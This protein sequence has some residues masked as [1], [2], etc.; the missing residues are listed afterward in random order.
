[1]KA[2]GTA[3]W[4]LRMCLIMYEGLLRLLKVQPGTGQN[5]SF[6]GICEEWAGKEGGW[7]AADGEEGGQEGRWGQQQQQTEVSQT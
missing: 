3:G 4:Q 7:R 2:G 5:F 1:M 6:A